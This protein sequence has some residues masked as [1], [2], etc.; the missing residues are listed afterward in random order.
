[1]VACPPG[2]RHLADLAKEPGPVSGWLHQPTLIYFI[3]GVS[4]N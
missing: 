3:A 2:L 4:S 1:M